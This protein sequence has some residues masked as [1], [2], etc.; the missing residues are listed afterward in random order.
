M[1]ATQPKEAL[2]RIL[3]AG[4]AS[5]DEVAARLGISQPT[6]SRWTAALMES[7]QLWR[8]GAARSSRYAAR[9]NVREMGSAFPIWLINPAG[10]PIAC[11]TL[12]ALANGEYGIDTRGSDI[13][14]NLPFLRHGLH[15]DLPWFLRDGLPQGFLGQLFAQAN[16]DLGLPEKLAR[17][18]GDDFLTALVRT[19]SDFPGALLVGQESL[20]RFMEHRSQYQRHAIPDTQRHDAYLRM[21]EEIMRSPHWVSSAGGEQPKFTAVVQTGNPQG[22]SFYQHVLVKFS[23]ALGQGEN[24]LAIRWRDLLIAEHLALVT[25]TEHGFNAAASRIILLR[26]GRACLESERFDRVGLSGR[27]P[28]LSLGAVDDHRYGIRDRWSS[29]VTRLHKDGLVPPDIIRAVRILEGF[30]HY[31]QNSDMHFGNLSLIPGSSGFALAPIYDMLPMRYAPNAG[32]LPRAPAAAAP[33]MASDLDDLAR[34]MAITFWRRVVAD[35]RVSPDFRG[36][37][38]R[39]SNALSSRSARATPVSPHRVITPSLQKK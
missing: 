19:G 26:N 13:P 25:L 6:F 2:A 23:P 37:A 35:Q 27:V 9:R 4:H 32:E 17:W 31:I 22:G 29:C 16:V 8:F 5:A 36:E 20:Q 24:P 7:G 14:S 10:E 15:E 39:Q 1:G 33:A 28:I 18:T 11:G 34:H 30:G 12:M 21:T 3:A 38:E